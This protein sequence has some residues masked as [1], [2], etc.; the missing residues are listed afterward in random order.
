M[1]MS[2]AIIIVIFVLASG[3]SS[4]AEEKASP[5]PGQES[6]KEPFAVV[7]LFTSEGCSSCPPA[8]EFLTEL[9]QKTEKTGRIFSLSFHVD[10]WNRLGWHDPFSN[11]AFTY[12]QR[13][14]AY[15][16]GT[17][18][19]STPQMI[20]NGTYGFNGANRVNALKYIKLVLKQPAEASVA[21]S[22]GKD[23]QRDSFV[24]EYL[25][26]ETAKEHILYLALVEKGIISR[27]LGGENAGMILHHANVVRAFKSVRLK[28]SPAGRIEFSLPDSVDRENLAVIGYIQNTKTMMILGAN[29]IDLKS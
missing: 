10:Y 13:T 2:R 11:S 3:I 15:A 24:V 28:K 9:V 21:L 27:V 23:R 8:D 16:L 6:A 14:Y 17:S 29:G 1:A 18:D 26:S 4:G 7:E 19:V 5:I 22:L 25:V 12:R 20:V